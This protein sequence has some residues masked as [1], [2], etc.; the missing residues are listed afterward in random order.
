MCPCAPPWFMARNRSFRFV[1]WNVRGLNSR[2]KCV[3][4]KSF[5]K[6]CKCGVVCLQETKL[7]ATSTDKFL[8]FCGFHIREFRAL[9]AVGTKGGIITAW[10][11]ALFECESS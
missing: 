3:T 7:A 4:V 6:G 11:P 9:D 10:N 2:D 1:S 5:I 8:S